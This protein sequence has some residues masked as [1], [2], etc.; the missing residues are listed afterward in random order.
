MMVSLGKPVFILVKKS[1]E[2]N[3]K[4]K[5]PSDI[6]WKRA[7]PYEEFIDIVEELS[8]QIKNRP[9]IE[10]ELSLIE[11]TQD[12]VAKIAPSL[13]QA[14]NSK[15]EELSQSQQERLT[16]LESLLKEA[17]LDKPIMKEK[18][19][20]IPPS[21]ERRIKEILERVEQMEKL[22][23]FPENPDIAFLRGNFYYERKEY[24]K[25]LELY[26]WAITLNPKA[27]S[28]W[29]NK[30][31]VLDELEKYEE[32]IA[33]HDKAIKIKPDHAS[34]WNSKG[35]VL[36]KLE[37][38][39]EAIACHDEAIKI[40]PDYTSA[41][42]NKGVV[43]GKLGR[44]QEA[45]QCYKEALRIDPNHVSSIQNLSEVLLILGSIKG[46]LKR[47]NEGINIAKKAED[48]AIC[49]FLQ[50]SALTLK[51]KREQASRE[52]KQLINYLRELEEGFKVTEWDFSPLLSAIE[53]K[54]SRGD[55][56]KIFSLVSLLKGEITI[57]EFEKDSS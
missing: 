47:I 41:W 6:L 3:L 34:A 15:I 22:T 24:G 17:K 11:E 48:K 46:A 20:V 42:Y 36:D 29:H 8:K 55:K 56:K 32:A 13:A 39:E 44:W 9:E 18:A 50:I 7:V 40:K 33:C 37:K 26:D 30:G 38:Y 5:L 35:V 45:R 52:I 43:L 2:E 31:I 16:K 28:A 12:V 21:L 23:G 51:G 27:A 49:R 1:K 4:K 54:L 10:A 19:E 57:K 14:L 53:K 25:A